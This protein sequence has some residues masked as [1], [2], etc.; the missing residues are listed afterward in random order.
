MIFGVLKSEAEAKIDSWGSGYRVYVQLSSRVLFLV[1][2][3]YVVESP[4]DY[5]WVFL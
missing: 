3:Q 1:G 5:L 2:N 4:K